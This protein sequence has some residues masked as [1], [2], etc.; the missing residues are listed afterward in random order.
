M[1]EELLIVVGS[2][3]HAAISWAPH[4]QTHSPQP[5]LPIQRQLIEISFPP[6][7][8]GLAWDAPSLDHWEILQRY[9][10]YHH[11]VAG[12]VPSRIDPSLC[13]GWL[14]VVDDP[15]PFVDD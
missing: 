2:R 4:E 6:L 15:K 3:D 8:I 13:S 11:T 9:R 12:D 1:I 14:M 5:C 7:E 10:D